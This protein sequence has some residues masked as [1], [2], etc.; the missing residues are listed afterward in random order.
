MALTLIAGAVAVFCLYQRIDD[1]IRRRVETII[2][3]HYKGLKVSLRAA[4]FV[5][6]KGVKIQDLFIVEPGVEG[7]RAELLH[8]EE[9]M[10]EFPTDWKQLLGGHPPVRRVTVRRATLRIMRRGDGTW[11]AGKLLPPPRFGNNPPQLIW[12][13]GTVEIFDPRP[14]GSSA[15]ASAAGSASAHPSGTLAEPV[16]YN[17]PVAPNAPAPQTPLVLRDVNLTLTPSEKAAVRRLHGTLRGEGFRSVEFQGW[18]DFQ[19]PAFAIGAMAVGVEIS[20]ELRD[21]LPVAAAHKVNGAGRFARSGR[22]PSS[23]SV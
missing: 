3:R 22:S 12:E 7:P 14:S 6:G 17:S 13:N 16:A 1:Q 4:Q 11:S 2:A 5:P 21:V 9:A 10:L 23:N 15:S 8:I 20:P 19:T 18:A